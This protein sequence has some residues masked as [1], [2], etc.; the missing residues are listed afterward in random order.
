ME[1]VQRFF[2][3]VS[4][5]IFESER[6]IGELPIH[7]KYPSIG[8]IDYAETVSYV[9]NIANKLLVMKEEDRSIYAKLII[10]LID[11]QLSI[12][13]VD[14]EETEVIYIKDNGDGS[15]TYSYK[16][17][18]GFT[19]SEQM[20]YVG[21]SLLDNVKYDVSCVVSDIEGFIQSVFN[22]FL[23]FGIDVLTIIKGIS[24]DSELEELFNYA[25]KY[26]KRVNDP[27]RAR[28]KRN[29]EILITANQQYDTIRALLQAAGWHGAD[30]TKTAEFV[31]WLTN[32]S[33]SYIRQGIL[34][35]ETRDKEKKE[36]DSKLIEEKFR[37]IGLTYKN[38][39]VKNE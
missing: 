31:A 19:K 25:I 29:P 38:G 18:Q 21:K 14:C 8:N 9:Y 4:N 7:S 30:N 11:V 16:E 32:G 34:S 28:R 26:G 22:L 37:L 20:I 36:A 13:W 33:K 1:N 27:I 6:K 5:F 10:E 35:G 24:N 12:G 23:D 39:K 15:E 2:D 3:G 17:K